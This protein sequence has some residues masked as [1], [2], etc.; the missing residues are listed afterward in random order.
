M[1]YWLVK[2]EPDVY[3]FEQL[4][5]DGRTNWDGV[6]N[7]QA[8][9]HLRAM[10]AG[11]LVL[12]YHSNE[13]KAVVGIARVVREAYQD[14]TT[15]EDWSAVD[16]EPVKPFVAPVTLAA[17]R[18]MRPLAKMVMLKSGRLSVS[19]VTKGQFDALLAAGKTTL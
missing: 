5:K 16:I 11:D 4:Q 10:K 17:M 19:P 2:S 1:S 18:K 12:Y 13:G 3:P 14:P 9:I 8:R 7:Y 15:D 6:R